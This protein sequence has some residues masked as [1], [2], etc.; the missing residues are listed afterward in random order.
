MDK[1]L[2]YLGLS[3]G[4]TIKECLCKGIRRVGDHC[5]GR[6]YLNDAT[7]LHDADGLSEVEHLAIVVRGNE[8]GCVCRAQIA[9]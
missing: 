3:L 6:V 2:R 5:Q 9:C 7:S 8:C 4:E 1:I